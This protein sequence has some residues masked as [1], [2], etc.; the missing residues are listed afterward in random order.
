[1]PGDHGEVECLVSPL[2]EE[3]KTTEILFSGLVT[4]PSEHESNAVNAL[5]NA[6]IP[7][8]L[9]PVEFLVDLDSERVADCGLSAGVCQAQDPQHHVS[10]LPG[11]Q[12]LSLI[13]SDLK[14]IIF[15]LFQYSLIKDL[16]CTVATAGDLTD[17]EVNGNVIALVTWKL[18]ST[19]LAICQLRIEH[20]TG[21][22]ITRQSVGQRDAK[23]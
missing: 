11:R 18:L 23:P 4:V 17:V 21:V 8:Q 10:F 22:I 7:V 13:N 20:G 6:S 15:I 5:T 14:A 2:L 19:P 9:E 16:N 3:G 1:M 12:G